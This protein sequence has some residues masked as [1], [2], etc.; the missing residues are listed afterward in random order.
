VAKKRMSKKCARRGALTVAAAA[1]ATA[2]TL[3]PIT[4][5]PNAEA[6]P[7]INLYTSGIVFQLL[8]AI[9]LLTNL[10]ADP[11][12]I[13]STL[14]ADRG[15]LNTSTI[16]GFMDGAYAA[17]RAIP[18]VNAADYPI[19]SLNNYN[20]VLIRNPGRSSGG[21]FTRLSPLFNLIGQDP[22]SA[23][24]VPKQQGALCPFPLA[25]GFYAP[26]KFDVTWAY[27]VLSD[28]PIVPN[29]FSIANSIAAGVFVT[30]LLGPTQTITIDAP[31]GNHYTTVVPNDLAL[32]EPLR[33][34]GRILALAGITLPVPN[35]LDLVANAVQPALTILVNI[36]Y[37]DVQTPSEGGTY[38]RTF[39][40][41]DDPNK[42]FLSESPLTLA[43]SLQVPGDVLEA[44]I[45]GIQS[46][47]PTGSLG[48]STITPQTEIA[49]AA[50]EPA[51]STTGDSP[52]PQSVQAVATAQAL[53]SA[54]S[55]VRASKSAA[56][57]VEPPVAEDAVSDT[58]SAQSVQTT[59]AA[60]DPTQTVDAGDTA[61]AVVEK[62]SADTGKQANSAVGARQR[63]KAA[64]KDV[65]EAIDRFVG[66]APREAADSTENGD[67]SKPASGTS[68]SD[69]S[70]SDDSSSGDS[71]SGDAAA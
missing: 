47:L 56:S 17:G 28:F 45:G 21:L 41:F 23:N 46:Q 67:E 25:C 9:P 35:P 65:R 37:S 30:N 16:F 6:A 43:E 31:G 38:N 22:V 3:G 58:P 29:P 10:P 68:S 49:A 44:L 57:A 1:T 2:M 7:G 8:P 53:P 70:S 61:A 27:D 62:K 5:A 64:V 32:L 26:S 13:S 50:S 52:A 54:E 19:P 20:F 60:P 42:P 33:L 55:D 59:V 24:V 36:G 39:D 66:K 48:P 4:P 51:P 34:P 40:Q 14:L 12:V 69:D 71:S 63:L 18:A 15:V 11:N